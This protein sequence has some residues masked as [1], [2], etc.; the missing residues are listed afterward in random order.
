M[1]KFLLC[2]VNIVDVCCISENITIEYMTCIFPFE[3]ALW[4]FFL[5]TAM[6]TVLWKRCIILLV[7]KNYG[8]EESRQE[9]EVQD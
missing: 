7:E 9:G 1:L 2:C 8:D 3:T 5:D 4:Y 6:N